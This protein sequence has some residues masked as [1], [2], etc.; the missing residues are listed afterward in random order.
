MKGLI[1]KR[2]LITGL[3]IV[4]CFCADAFAQNSNDGFVAAQEIDS[5]YFTIYLESGVNLQQLTLNLSVPP[6]IKVIIG[7]STSDFEAFNLEN[8]LDLLFLAV[9][10]IMDIRLAKFK[11]RVKVCKDD[12]SLAAV[13]ERLYGMPV[14]K[15]GGFF[16]PELETIYVDSGSVTLNVLGHELS[17]ALQCKYFV[18]MPPMKVQEVLSGFV[19]YQLRKETG[20]LPKKR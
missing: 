4:S 16:V 1:I 9:C 13:A 3:I 5:R 7:K 20:T 6:D 15:S 11:C 10:E 8:Q 17:H 18:V 12:S 19:E 14:A 2:H